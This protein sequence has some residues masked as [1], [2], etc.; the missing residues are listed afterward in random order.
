[1]GK[2]I[3]NMEARLTRVENENELLKLEL[4]ATAQLKERRAQLEERNKQLRKEL[5]T[6]EHRRGWIRERKKA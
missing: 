4:S 6:G 1:M 5:E 2:K 3:V